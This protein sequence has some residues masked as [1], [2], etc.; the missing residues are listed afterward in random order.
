MTI[1][2][3]FAS[4][5]ISSSGLSAQRRRID[6]VAR[7]L[8]NIETTRTET[9]GPYQREIA[10]IAEVKPQGSFQAVLAKI[11]SQIDLTNQRH[12]RPSD[13]SPQSGMDAG[14]VNIQEIAVDQT[15]PRMKYD[16]T[17][18]DADANGYV[19]YPNIN[20]VTEMVDMIG[21]SR[22]YEANLTV[23]DATKKLVK[24]SLEI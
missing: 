16:P 9:G 17:H 19:A 5:N 10:V 13:Y 24:K 20:V 23:V 2:N 14:G 18:P 7:N 22:A 3:I 6:T 12:M 21:A 4:L 8:A 11:N 15:L 1:R